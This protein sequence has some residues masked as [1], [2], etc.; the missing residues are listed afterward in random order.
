MFV[1]NT[2]VWVLKGVSISVSSTL[3]RGADFSSTD[4]CMYV[5][6]HACMYVWRRPRLL[7]SR[8]LF[9]WC[10]L[11]NGI[12][13]KQEQ[14]LDHSNN[15]KHITKANQNKTT[16]KHKNNKNTPTQKQTKQTKTHK[17]QTEET[18]KNKNKKQHE[19]QSNNKT[20]KQS[21]KTK[22]K[23]KQNK[24]KTPFPPTSPAREPFSNPPPLSTLTLPLLKPG[25][26][27]GWGG[28]ENR[29]RT[30]GPQDP[31]KQKQRLN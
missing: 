3:K 30:A 7:P 15:T 22:T 23:P 25:Q 27:E 26:R 24:T 1:W 19:K 4:V 5:C 21:R 9:C 8:C 11:S 2:E 14:H 16:R 13:S 17:K 31:T 10:C 6:M 29:K 18:L 20:K 12:G 28:K